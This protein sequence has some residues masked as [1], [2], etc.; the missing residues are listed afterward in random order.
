MTKARFQP[1]CNADNINLGYF[2]GGR[3]FPRSSTERN[4]ALF[5][6]NNHFCLIWKSEKVSFKQAIKEMKD[7]FKTVGN[8]FTEENLN[9]HFKYESIPG[10][11]ES[12]LSKFIA[13]DLETH[14]IDRARPYCISFHR[15]SKVSGRYYR[16]PTR[17]ELQKSIKDTIASDGDNCI[18]T[19]LDYCLKLKVD[20]RKVKN[21]ILEY[22]LQMHAHNGSNF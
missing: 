9:S 21:K 12:Y 2:E 17:E 14:N 20:E 6:Y 11:N 15:K 16:D 7:S 13:Y 3:V 4:K 5:L 1:F 19:A 8:Y 22:K 10:K 18:S